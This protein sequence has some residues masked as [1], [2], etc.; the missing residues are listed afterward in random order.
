MSVRRRLPGYTDAAVAAAMVGVLYYVA[1]RVRMW[2]DF[3]FEAGPAVQHLM[4][5]DIHG[6][7]ALTPVYG[8]SLLLGSPALALGGA[9][10]GLNGAYRL[11]WLFCATAVAVLALVLARTQRAEGRSPLSRW[12][13]IGLLIANPAA[14]WAIK[15]GHPE[16]LLA[17]ALCVGGMLLVVRGRITSGAILLGLAVASKQWALLALPIALAATPRNDR[18]RLSALAGC[19]ALTLFLPLALANT[20]H[21]VTTNRSIA[22]A[23]IFFRPQQI[24]WTLHLD[25]LRRLGG[26]HGTTFGL[27]PIA[28]VTRYSRPLIGVVAVLLG[29][30][31]WL[32][33]HHV[34]PSDAMLILALVMLLRGML[35]PWNEIYY[36]LPFLFSLA[37]WEV[38][39]HRRAPLFTL[40]ASCLVW[41]GFEAVHTS[42]GD[43]QNLFYV[44]W[45]I[46]ACVL[47][48]R[49][50]LHLSRTSTTLGRYETTVRSLPS[51]VSTS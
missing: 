24:W 18:L 43:L 29:I 6:F 31:Y 45:A 37:A 46:P 15:A 33:R 50:S 27:T 9:L 51:A 35:D 34:Q 3:F 39:S 36:Q 48:T 2:L 20:S 42:S 26:P 40:A 25:Y 28:L 32:R 4:A 38:C 1:M 23:S 7:L 10:G 49:R 5:G 21:F 14:E 17:A 13:L 44:T 12:L 41:L 8:G 30:A 47:M 16:E 11:E 19:A 22:S